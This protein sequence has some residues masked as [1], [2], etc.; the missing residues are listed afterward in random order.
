[1]PSIRVQRIRSMQG[2]W[3]QKLQYAVFFAWTL[4]WTWRWRPQWIYA[5][6]LLSCPVVWWV[7]KLVDAR[8]LYHEHDC[9]CLDKPSPWFMNQALAYRTKVARN[10]E[11][12]VLPQQTRLQKFLENT[13]RTKPAYCVWNCPGSDEIEKLGSQQH[14]TDRT[15]ELVLYYHGSITPDRLPIQLIIAASRFKGAVRVLVAGYEN[16]RK[17]WACTRVDHRGN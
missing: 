14:P 11:L 17:H 5:S 6:D 4:W 10:A 3:S 7:R 1:M 16:S 13:G 2:G 8:V 15:H 12:C 9:P